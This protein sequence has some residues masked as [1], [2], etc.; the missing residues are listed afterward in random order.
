MAT[1]QS[2]FKCRLCGKLFNGVATGSERIAF[3]TITDACLGIR[4]EVIQAPKLNQEHFCADG[5]Y[6]VADF[7]G[8]KKM[9]SHKLNFK[10]EQDGK[11]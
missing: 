11:V 9:N 6:G 10:G 8:Y 5:S 2:I 1:Y 4:S 3:E 7:Q